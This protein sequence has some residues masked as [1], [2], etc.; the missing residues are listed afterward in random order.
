MTG[1]AEISG[2]VVFG[3]NTGGGVYVAP[4]GDFTLIRGTIAKNVTIGVVSSADGVHVASGG[5]LAMEGGFI[6]HNGE[7]RGMA[8]GTLPNRVYSGSAGVFA[9]G[10][11]V[12]KGGK[13]EW[14]EGM[15]IFSGGVWVESGSSPNDGFT[16]MGEGKITNNKSELSSGG[17]WIEPGK[18]QFSKKTKMFIM[19]GGD[20]LDNIGMDSLINDFY[21]NSSADSYVLEG[22]TI[23]K[24]LVEDYKPP[25]WT[26]PNPST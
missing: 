3:D 24:E 4:G 17:V 26:R 5:K 21:C 9:A 15:N 22:G 7:G 20:I 16:M 14:N 2:N 18:E 10:E 11:F 6:T 23:S 19:K 1:T 12:M 13:I 8:V 25:E